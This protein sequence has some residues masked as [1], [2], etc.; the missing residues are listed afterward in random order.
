MKSL[1]LSIERRRHETRATRLKSD[2]IV[3]GASFGQPMG[4]CSVVWLFSISGVVVVAAA[5]RRVSLG[6]T[7]RRVGVTSGAKT[8]KHTRSTWRKQKRREKLAHFRVH[9]Q[10]KLAAD[11]DDESAAWRPTRSAAGSETSRSIYVWLL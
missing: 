2:F 5:V 11:D 8:H 6:P 1:S 9:V 3:I 4:N 7:G 10:M